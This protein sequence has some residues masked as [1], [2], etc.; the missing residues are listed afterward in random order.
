MREKLARFMY[1]RYGADNLNNML[2]YLALLL[3]FTEVF[4]NSRALNLAVWICLFLS[5]YRSFSRDYA[6]RSLENQ[7]FLQLL[8]RFPSWFPRFNN[9]SMGYSQGSYGY[10]YDQGY[11]RPRKA[12]RDKTKKIYK[13]PS[14]K[15]K[16]RV[17]KG[18]GKIM[19]TCPK[20]HTEFQKRT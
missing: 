17:P 1:G 13:C 9:R 6:K 5:L 14:C 18:K 20:C 10:G 3:C 16:V 15:Q 12:A 19:I 7:K 4:I 2:F 11:A 8:D